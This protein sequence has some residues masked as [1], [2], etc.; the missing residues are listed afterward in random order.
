VST[1][2][3]PLEGYLPMALGYLALTLPLSWLARRLEIKWRV[4]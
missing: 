1:S 2:S 4:A 3:A